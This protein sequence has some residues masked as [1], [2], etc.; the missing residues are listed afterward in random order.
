MSF[1]NIHRIRN[2]MRITIFW[3]KFE[4]AC[5]VRMFKLKR[6]NLIE[7]RNIIF[8][9]QISAS[10]A[11]C[12]NAQ[13]AL[14]TMHILTYQ[15]L[16]SLQHWHYSNLHLMGNN[17]RKKTK[18]KPYL[19]L[20]FLSFIQNRLPSIFQRFIFLVFSFIL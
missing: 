20:I 10:R 8:S 18:L 5:A 13:C 3:S 9:M 7:S 17:K 1:V 4:W 19:N 15:Q 12:M 2:G 11:Q 16:M 14:F 6:Q